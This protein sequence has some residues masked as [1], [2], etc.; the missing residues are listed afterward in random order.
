MVNHFLESDKTSRS[1]F[2]PSLFGRQ[3][4]DYCLMNVCALF[5]WG[6]EEV[7]SGLQFRDLGPG[8]SV[9]RWGPGGAQPGGSVFTQQIS[10]I[11]APQ[12][13]FHLHSQK[14]FRTKRAHLLRSRAVLLK[15][16][17]RLLLEPRAFFRVINVCVCVTVGASDCIREYNSRK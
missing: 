17:A 13:A 3:E 9:T 5:L 6:W 15:D 7:L 12:R 1:T 16:G 8:A 10:L 2:F 4:L 14:L 11:R